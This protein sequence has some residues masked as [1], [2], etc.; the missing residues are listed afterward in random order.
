MIYF[1]QILHTY[2]FN[3]CRD[4]GMQNSDIVLSSVSLTGLGQTVKMLI[5]LGPYDISEP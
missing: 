5:T 4:T 3:Y 1:D 2:T